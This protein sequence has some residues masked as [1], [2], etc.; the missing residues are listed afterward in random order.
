MES[1][2]RIPIRDDL[3]TAPLESEEAVR[4]AGSQCLNCGEVFLGKRTVCENCSA[5]QMGPM[6]FSRH[7]TLWGY[8][9]VRHEP[10]TGYK[11]PGPFKPYGLGLVELPEGLRVM[12]PLDGEIERLRIGMKMELVVYALYTKEPGQ[13]VLAFKFKVGDA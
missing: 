11:V 5:Q 13:E 7:G 2:Q 6:A 3:F 12:A 10:P 1:K 9:V 4:L 8:T